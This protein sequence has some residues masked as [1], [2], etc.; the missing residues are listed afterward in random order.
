MTWNKYGILKD[1]GGPMS[2]RLADGWG[3][4]GMF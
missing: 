4:M 2:V 1:G 3:P